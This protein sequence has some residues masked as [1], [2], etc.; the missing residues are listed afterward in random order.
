MMEAAGDETAGY[1][2]S[3]SVLISSEVTLSFR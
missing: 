3:S 1:E 2:P